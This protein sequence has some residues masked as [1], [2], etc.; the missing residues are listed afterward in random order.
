MDFTLTKYGELIDAIK[1]AGYQFMTFEQYLDSAKLPEDKKIVILRHDVDKRARNSKATAELETEK[2][3]V[4]SYYFRVVK[5]S[6]QPSVI[7]T[8]ATMG[9][10][11]GYHYE[12]MSLC[13]GDVDA[14]M[15]HFIKWLDYFRNMYPVRT[16]CM[17]GAPQ[18]RYDSRD[19]WRSRPDG[20]KAY[21]YHDYGIIGEPYF[22]IDFGTFLYLTDTGRCWDGYKV[23]V[24]DKIPEHQDEWIRRGWSFHT[25]DDVIRALRGESQ[26]EPLPDKIMFTTHPQ[27]W[28]NNMPEW[29]T[30]YLLQSVKNVVKRILI[31]TR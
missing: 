2:G 21:N 19:L 4:A 17:H 7:H 10:E 25:T 5:Q 16:I 15:R 28:S 6:F 29:I 18:S 24:R 13:H 31:A 3:A 12:D 14:A 22:D 27:R 11:I 1:A 26:G 23:S 8:I 9:H 20:Q 30:E